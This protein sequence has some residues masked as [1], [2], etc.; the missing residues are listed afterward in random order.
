MNSLEHILTAQPT[1]E[2]YKYIVEQIAEVL[3]PMY[4]NYQFRYYPTSDETQM[5]HGLSFQFTRADNPEAYDNMFQRTMSTRAQMPG[6]REEFQR[7]VRDEEIIPVGE[8]IEIVGLTDEENSQPT[9]ISPIN[10]GVEGDF[11]QVMIAFI[12]KKNSPEYWEN[13]HAYD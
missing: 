2:D 8:G 3:K 4:E 7:A 1:K 12:Q 5:A 13:I 11:V 9:G 6:I 10:S